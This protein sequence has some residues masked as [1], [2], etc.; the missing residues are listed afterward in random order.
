MQSAH[1]AWTVFN[2]QIQGHPGAPMGTWLTSL[3]FFGVA[4]WTTT[5]QTQVGWPR[6]FLSCLTAMVQC[7]FTLCFTLQATDFQLKI[8]KNFRQLH[9]KTP[10]HPRVR[11]R[12]TVSRDNDGSSGIGI[13]LTLLVWQ[14]QRKHW[15][16]SSTRRS[17]HRRPLRYAFMGDGC[18][19]EGI[20]HEACVH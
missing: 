11:L 12:S 14:W 18:L 7:W 10:G 16:H 6:P 8:W 13:A 3:K 15:L 9:S 19:M 4:T 17:R 1:L 2:K 5:Q 20:S